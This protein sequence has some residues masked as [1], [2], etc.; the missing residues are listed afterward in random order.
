MFAE[1]TISELCASA[2]SKLGAANAILGWYRDRVKGLDGGDAGFHAFVSVFEGPYDA[3]APHRVEEQ[4]LFGVPVAIKDNMEV[5][6]LPMTCG[7]VALQDYVPEADCVVVQRLKA[8]GAVVIG[9]TAMSEFAW[10][11][12]DTVGS[13]FGMTRNPYDRRY[14]CGGSSGGSAVAVSANLAAVGIGTDTGCSVRAPAAMTGLVGLRPTFGLVDVQ[15][16]M[17]MSRFMDT[18]GPLARTALDAAKVLKV[19]ANTRVEEADGRTVDWQFCVD[20]V[21][22]APSHGY[23]L[24]NLAA[25]SNANGS[26]PEVLQIYETF[27]DQVEAH[28]LADVAPLTPTAWPT[29]DLRPWY[30]LYRHDVDSYLARARP[31]HPCNTLGEIV[32]S[33]LVHPLQADALKGWASIDDTP[34]DDPFAT[35]RT[36]MR[37]SLRNALKKDFDHHR[38]DAMV[39]PTFRYAAPL[40]GDRRSPTGNN[41]SVA[42]IAGF[43]AISI[44][45]GITSA[46]LPVSAQLMGLPWSEQRLL[47]IAHA[48]EVAIPH[49]RSP[50]LSGPLGSV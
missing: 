35:H 34:S 28:D 36:S 6:G 42:S 8:A 10:G 43:P 7:S 13:A 37:V 31:G 12:T 30:R 41:N 17:P 21:R 44:P 14:A 19:I 32:V 49:R 25:L 9:K 22:R 39:F 45:I 46:G 5:A 3:P 2:S 15:G 18:I 29:L 20:A 33:G 40:S 50:T 24:A 47:Q 48:V 38:L 11:V 26:D 1:A 16:I 4:P 23:R 27:L